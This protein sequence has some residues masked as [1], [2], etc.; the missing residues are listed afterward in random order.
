GVASYQAAIASLQTSQASY[1]RWVG[2][3][4]QNLS[5]QYDFGGLLPASLDQAIVLATNDHPAILSAKAAIRASQAGLD[6]AQAAF[7][8]TLSLVGSLCT[9]N[10]GMGADPGSGSIRVS[11]SI[12]IYSGG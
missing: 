10:C 11:L 12:P 7:G 4:P 9:W 3:K 1:E 6:G 5:A 8:P 2:H